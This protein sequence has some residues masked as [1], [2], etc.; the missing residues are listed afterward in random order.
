[1]DENVLEL[2]KTKVMDGPFIFMV[3][4]KCNRKRCGC[5]RL[6]HE[7]FEDIVTPCHD[8]CDCYMVHD[9]LFEVI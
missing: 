8:N 5:S 7:N 6:D 2:L 4:D 1:M 3:G 9:E